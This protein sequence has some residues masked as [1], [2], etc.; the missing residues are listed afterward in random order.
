MQLKLYLEAGIFKCLEK[1]KIKNQYR[2][3]MKT[4]SQFL[5]TLNKRVKI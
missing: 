1:R 3:T 2:A 4:V 5:K